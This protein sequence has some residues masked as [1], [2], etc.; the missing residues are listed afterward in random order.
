MGGVG[1]Q[2]IRQLRGS[3]AAACRAHLGEQPFGPPDNEFLGVCDALQ[4]MRVREARGHNERG[5]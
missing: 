4:G 2:S 5:W 3:G 1:N